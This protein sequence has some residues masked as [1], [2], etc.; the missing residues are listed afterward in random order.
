MI[1][2][3]TCH[4][5]EITA[6]GKQYNQIL[7]DKIKSHPTFFLVLVA[8]SLFQL[9]HKIGKIITTFISMSTL[10]IINGLFFAVKIYCCNHILVTYLIALDDTFYLYI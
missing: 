3:A 10:I 2:P 6:I 7:M 4:S 9:F 5:N 1:P 8:V